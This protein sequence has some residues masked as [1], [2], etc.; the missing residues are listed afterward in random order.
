LVNQGV[1]IIE[2]PARRKPRTVGSFLPMVSKIRPRN[3]SK[4]ITKSWAMK[5]Q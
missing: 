4:A 2:L 1:P 3:I 5:P